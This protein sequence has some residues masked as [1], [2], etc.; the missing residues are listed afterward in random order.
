MRK[1]SEQTLVHYQ[2]NFYED[3][4]NPEEYRELLEALHL[5]EPLQKGYLNARE[6]IAG[7]PD[8]LYAEFIRKADLQT[9]LSFWGLPAYDVNDYH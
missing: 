2:L 5:W 6:D 1:G 9:N 8:F 4:F 3:T 7:N